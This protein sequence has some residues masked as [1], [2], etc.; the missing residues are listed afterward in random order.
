MIH[1]SKDFI[2][3]RDIIE[4]IEELQDFPDTCPHCGEGL[5]TFEDFMEFDSYD[6]VN[7]TCPDC[8]NSLE[9]DEDEKTELDA[10]IELQE[11]CENCPDWEYG[12]TL[13]RDSYFTEYAQDLAEDIGAIDRDSNWPATHIDWDAAAD[14]LKTDYTCVDFD[15]VEYWIRS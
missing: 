12:A 3:S 11:Q 15:G 4:R 9:F 1:N 10:L 6:S 2:D 8:E 14:E 13:I 5:P 7:F